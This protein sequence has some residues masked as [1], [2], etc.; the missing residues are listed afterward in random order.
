MD[1]NNS[2]LTRNPGTEFRSDVFYKN[3]IKG[4]ELAYAHVHND[5]DANFLQHELTKSITISDE[6]PVKNPLI[7]E[8]LE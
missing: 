2:I 8:V 6:T 3:K 5:N 7:Y 1:N 4:Q